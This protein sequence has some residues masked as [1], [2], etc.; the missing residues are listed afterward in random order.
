MF[1]RAWV[2]PREAL[3][4]WSRG[5]RYRL[6]SRQKLIAGNLAFVLALSGVIALDH[7]Y[8]AL[9]GTGTLRAFGQ[10][11]AVMIAWAALAPFAWMIRR[12]QLDGAART[13]SFDEA[14]KAAATLLQNTA[15]DRDAATLAASF[16]GSL[17]TFSS[18]DF[19]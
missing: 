16:R 15:R 2:G 14:V 18:T 13:L 19:G 4:A 6:D 10:A 1:L 12:R 5:D 11:A 7:V 17:R 9:F 3:E 8:G